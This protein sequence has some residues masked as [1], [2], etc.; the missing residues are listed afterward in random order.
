MDQQQL[1]MIVLALI[2]I[3]ISVSLFRSNAIYGKRDILIQEISAN[4]NFLTADTEEYIVQITGTVSEAVASSDSI[5]V[6][7]FVTAEEIYT[8]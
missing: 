6:E 4:G 2:A 1:S 3:T 8:V 7:T 5:K